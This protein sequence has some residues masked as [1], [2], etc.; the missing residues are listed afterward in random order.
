MVCFE[1]YLPELFQKEED[2][3]QSRKE[4]TKELANKSNW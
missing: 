2:Q 3:S 4:M 1:Q